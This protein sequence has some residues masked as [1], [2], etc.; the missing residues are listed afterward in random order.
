MELPPE[1]K[2]STAELLTDPRTISRYMKTS[3][4]NRDIL[5]N[6]V[7]NL[8]WDPSLGPPKLNLIPAGW[9][10]Q[11]THLKN[12]EMPISFS[13][14][15]DV[16][17]ISIDKLEIVITAFVSIPEFLSQFSDLSTKDFSF[18]FYLSGPSIIH[19]YGTVLRHDFWDIES[20]R[21]IMNIMEHRG[22]ITAV[23]DF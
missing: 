6:C 7:I 14:G 4:G 23:T 12:V 18:H 15:D 2:C 19:V 11:F 10:N 5:R 8:S 22:G 1:L 13:H 16:R 21:D 17:N 3:L 20:L 9:V